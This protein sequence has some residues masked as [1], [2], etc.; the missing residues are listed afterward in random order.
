MLELY[1]KVFN[2]LFLLMNL[3]DVIEF[4]SL[5]KKNTNKKKK[6]IRMLSA[7]EFAWR[8]KVHLIHVYIFDPG[9]PL[10]QVVHHMD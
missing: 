10:L 1:V 9:K 4:Y 2:N 5:K 8:F 3:M 6:K 7:T